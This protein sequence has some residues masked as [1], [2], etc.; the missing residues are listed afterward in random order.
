MPKSKPLVFRARRAIGAHFDPEILLGMA[1][2]VWSLMWADEQEE[3]GRSLS[4]MDIY[5]EA[6]DAPDWAER[7]AGRLAT[8]ILRINKR[9]PEELY[10]EA[11]RAGFH[12]NRETFGYYLGM[13]AV[14]HGVHWTDDVPYSKDRPE[15]LVPSYEFYEGAEQGEPDTRF[16][17]K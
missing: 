14:G 17:H 8:C 15:I 5:E 1:R 6:P 16:I 11:V 12:K 9:S 4:G 3:R 2:G 7:W 10:E 13:Q